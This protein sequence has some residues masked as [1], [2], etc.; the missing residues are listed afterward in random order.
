MENHV[1]SA[2][3]FAFRKTQLLP[4]TDV[5]KPTRSALTLL[6]EITILY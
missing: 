2:R 4:G 6:S 5:I 1:I 3:L